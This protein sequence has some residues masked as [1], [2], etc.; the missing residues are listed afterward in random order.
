MRAA[1]GAY[2]V[3]EP[4]LHLFLDTSSLELFVNDGEET[5]TARFFPHPDD[6]TILFGTHG[7]LHMDIEKWDLLR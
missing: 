5:F 6:R 1:G 2:G 7:H 3:S 4:S